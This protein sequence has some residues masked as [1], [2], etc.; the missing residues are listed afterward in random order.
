MVTIWAT[1]EPAPSWSK[2]KTA[3]HLGR[4][5]TQKP[6]LDNIEKSILDGLNGIAFKDDS[7]VAD[8]S[9]RKVWGPVARVVVTVEALT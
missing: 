5:H 2:K 6:D 7:Q 3:E 9:K 8:V 4:Y 1:F